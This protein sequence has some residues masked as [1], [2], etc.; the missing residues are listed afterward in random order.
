MFLNRT[1]TVFLERVRPDS[2]VANPMCM[3]KTRAV[4]NIIHTLLAVNRALVA[5]SVA[6]AAVG[7]TSAVASSALASAGANKAAALAANAASFF[8]S[9]G[10]SLW[11]W[12]A[13]G[14]HGVTPAGQKLGDSLV[15][16]RLFLGCFALLAA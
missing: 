8:M 14:A 9:S 5:A 16:A 13:S 4:A 1:F 3:M 2:R 10:F 11:G 7:A 12:T 15:R 6:E